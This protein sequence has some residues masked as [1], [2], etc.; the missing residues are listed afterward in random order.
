MG[1][2]SEMA[3]R[4]DG[5]LR[6]ANYFWERDRE[7]I[8]PGLSGY[9]DPD[10]EEKYRTAI[11]GLIKGTFT[12]IV[13]AYGDDA[14]TDLYHWARRFLVNQHN[15]SQ[16]FTWYMLLSTLSQSKSDSQFQTEIAQLADPLEEEFGFETEE[17]DTQAISRIE[18]AQLSPNEYKM[19]ELE[20]TQP[21]DFETVDLSSLARSVI[22][23]NH[24]YRFW[25]V[26]SGSLEPSE[27]DTWLWIG[28]EQAERLGMPAEEVELPVVR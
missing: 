20:V 10:F 8:A 6:A 1:V 3:R 16:W 27:V 25:R 23:S 26:L 22:H 15:K 21:G 7:G 19:I 5:L 2:P 17:A 24:T 28:Y 12:I 11:E 14:A 4:P 18:L 9:S 13:D